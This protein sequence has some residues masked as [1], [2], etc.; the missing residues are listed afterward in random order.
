MNPADPE[1]AERLEKLLHNSRASRAGWTSQ[2]NLRLLLETHEKLAA[3]VRE[4]FGSHC[5]GKLIARCGMDTA[6]A[7]F[8][9][10]SGWLGGTF[11]GIDAD[12]ECI[13]QH[14]RSGFCDYLVTDLDEAIRI[15]RSAVHAGQ[16][17]SVGL[18]ADP[19]AALDELIRLGV[20]PDVLIESSN[21]NADA[22]QELKRIGSIVLDQ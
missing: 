4:R 12:A 19:A 22:I 17:V 21:S 9:F 5:R 16:P 10:I 3:L 20:V 2:E 13:K 18:A 8:S 15:L 1:I 6:G 14:I 11:L 7:A